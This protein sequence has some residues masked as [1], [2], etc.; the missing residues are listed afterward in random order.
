V[1]AMT[2]AQVLAAARSDPDAQPLTKAN[3][4]RMKRVPQA[5]VIRQAQN[6]SQEEFAET[7]AIPIGTLRDWEQGRVEP[8]QAARA[9][10]KVIASYPRMVRNAVGLPLRSART[11]LQE[12]EDIAQSHAL[13]FERDLHIDPATE[14]ALIKAEAPGGK[15]FRLFLSAE[16]ASRRWNLTG[17][18]S[19]RDAKR[20]TILENL[21]GL[22]AIAEAAHRLGESE[23]RL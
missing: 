8:D 17:A 19:K 14:T 11:H 22:Q 6:M 18:P 9:Y 16:F 7:Y 2:D 13:V 1:R 20:K 10:L 5:K 21:A 15:L 12:D 23:L 4:K 3:F